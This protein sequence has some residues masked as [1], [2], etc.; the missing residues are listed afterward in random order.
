MKIKFF[1]LIISS[2]FSN[3]LKSQNIENLKIRDTIYIMFDE[4]NRNFKKTIFPSPKQGYAQRW[5]QYN[6][7]INDKTLIF[8]HIRYEVNDSISFKYNC[9]IKT[10]NKRSFMRNNKNKIIYEQFFLA[11]DVCFLC[12][13]IFTQKKVLYI[14]DCEEKKNEN[15]VLYEVKAL[16]PC[17][18]LDD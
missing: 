11:Y 14:I 17:P 5:Y 7:N 6:F 10:V 2:L 12:S 8:D 3:V 4:K 18:H 15:L 1:F 13:E 16:N 9:S